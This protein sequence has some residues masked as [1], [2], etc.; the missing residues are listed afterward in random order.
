M[1]DKTPDEGTEDIEQWAE[2]AHHNVLGLAGML[3]VAPE[4]Y[5]QDPLA[6][7]PGLQNY[8]DRLPLSEFEQSDWITLHTDL[9]SYLG[10]F[11][12]RRH[13]ATWRRVADESSAAGYRYIIEA[14]GLDGNVHRVEPFDVVMEEFENLP[15]EIG[16]MIANAE[17]SLHVT[18][19]LDG[20]SLE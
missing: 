19:L 20:E 13:E 8:V 12:A 5:L 10:D 9:T 3:G 11:L 15:I 1:Q 2:G 18:P 16:R 14:K 7:L 17:V 6:L 4:Q